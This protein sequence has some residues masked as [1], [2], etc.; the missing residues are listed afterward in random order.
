MSCQCASFKER[1]IVG[2]ICAIFAG[3][4]MLYFD[5]TFMNP[6]SDFSFSL[7][8]KVGMP[9]VVIPTFSLIIITITS[10]RRF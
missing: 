1:V 8:T 2:L 9:L 3:S 6:V 5:Y 10:L 4:F 7:L